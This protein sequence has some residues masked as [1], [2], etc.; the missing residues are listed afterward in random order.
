MSVFKLKKYYNKRS[1]SIKLNRAVEIVQTYFVTMHSKLLS[2]TPT[3]INAKFDLSFVKLSSN[4]CLFAFVFTLFLLGYNQTCVAQRTSGIE[5]YDTLQIKEQSPRKASLY[6]AVLPGLGQAYNK[7]YWKIPIIYAGGAALIYSLNYASKKYTEYKK[8]LIMVDEDSPADRTFVKNWLGVKDYKKES[9]E[10]NLLSGI[11]YYRRN[12]DLSA[13]G[14]G[15]IYLANIIDAT[16]DA[17]L[18]DYNVTQD[19]S[20]KVKPKV[21]YSPYSQDIGL[22]CTLRF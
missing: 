16:V 5:E 13:I 22:S 17:Y 9:L 14:L 4:K 2:A 8:I 3:R 15:A 21:I 19:L 18:Y 20:L 11:D 7:K 10:K 6:S 1:L 12:R